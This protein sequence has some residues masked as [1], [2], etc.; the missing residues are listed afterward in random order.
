M[1]NLFIMLNKKYLIHKKNFDL[2]YKKGKSKNSKYFFI[3]YLPNYK[4]YSQFGIIISKKKEK[5]AVKRNRLKRILKSALKNNLD[6]I[7]KGYYFVIILKRTAKEE[8]LRKDLFGIL[9]K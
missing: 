1:E 7:Q 6:K 5:L 2:I 4:N 3:K 8:S 9:T